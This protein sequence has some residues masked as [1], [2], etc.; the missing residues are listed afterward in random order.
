MITH[1]DLTLDDLLLMHSIP[2]VY[3]LYTLRKNPALVILTLQRPFKDFS[4]QYATLLHA[5]AVKPKYLLQ[6]GSPIPAIWE[7][8]DEVHSHTIANPTSTP[9]ILSKV[10]HG[11][12]EYTS[13]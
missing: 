1:I 4:N 9:P 8:V 13:E 7:D 3:Y 5:E 10:I 12:L 6:Q 11:R 2:N